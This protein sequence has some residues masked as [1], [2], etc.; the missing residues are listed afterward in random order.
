MIFVCFK[1]QSC[2]SVFLN[3][4]CLCILTAHIFLINIDDDGVGDGQDANSRGPSLSCLSQRLNEFK[5]SNKLACLSFSLS[6]RNSLSDCMCWFVINAATQT[7]TT[8][9]E[10]KERNPH[11]DDVILQ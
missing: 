6:C 10:E 9:Y 8:T 5:T 7:G 4:E 1:Y 11:G 2:L 3:T